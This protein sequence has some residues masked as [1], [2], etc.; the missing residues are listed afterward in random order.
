VYLGALTATYGFSF[1][2]P[3]GTNYRIIVNGSE[4]GL[5]IAYLST[6]VFIINVIDTQVFYYQNG[7]LKATQTC[8]PALYGGAINLYTAGTTI[9]NIVYLPIVG[10]ATGATGATGFGATGVTGPTGPAGSGLYAGDY[11]VQAILSADQT[12]TSGG[13]DKTIQFVDAYDPQNWWNSSTYRFTPTI[14]GYYYF[15]VGVWWKE[16]TG[17]TGQNNVQV[18]KNTNSQILIQNAVNTTAGLSAGDSKLVYLNGTT[19]YLDVTAFTATTQ[20]IQKGTVDG[21]GTWFT[22]ALQAAGSLTGPTGVAGAAGTTGP[23]GPSGTAGSA[24]ATGATGATGPQPTLTAG[25]TGAV[26]VYN[27]GTSTY[28]YNSNVNVLPSTMQLYMN[29]EPASNSVYQLGSAANTWGPAW[30]SQTGERFSTIITPAE[31]TTLNWNDTSIWYCSSMNANFTGNITNLPTQANRSYVIVTN[32]VQ[33]ATPY[34]MSNLQIAGATT[35]INW[36]NGTTPTPAASK[37]EVE[38]ITLFYQGGAW[39]ALGQ[40]TSFG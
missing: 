32:L 18:R 19:D 24:G 36:F 40:Y 29:L 11:I 12:I 3:T 31:T 7:I 16:V 30:F 15:S 1:S 5:P 35:T 14:A 37:F 2:T 8:T 6:D 10:G 21:S 20:D 34:Y 39:R 33:G 22:A 13:L 27:T 25:S 17:G 26:Q 38:S 4:T 9:S 28:G 23:T